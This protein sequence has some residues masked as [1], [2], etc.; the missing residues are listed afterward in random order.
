MSNKNLFLE[1]DL[2]NIIL[3]IKSIIQKR[4]SENMFCTFQIGQQ[5]LTKQI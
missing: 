3:T 1:E 4:Q 5:T 2:R